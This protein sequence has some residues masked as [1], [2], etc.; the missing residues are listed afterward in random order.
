MLPVPF[1]ESLPRVFQ[2]DADEVR[3]A[4]CDKVD[5]ILEGLKSDVQDIQRLADPGAAPSE[6]LAAFGE[7]L[8][9]GIGTADA[10]PVKREKISGAVAGHKVRYTWAVVKSRIDFISGASASLYSELADNWPVRLGDGE[11][12]AVLGYDW[13]MRG[14]LAASD[15]IFRIGLGTEF[16]VPGNIFVDVGVST[17][18]AAQVAQIVYDITADGVP[19][20]FRITLGYTSGGAFVAYPGGVIG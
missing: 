9:A 2:D 19:A 12:Y 15:G 11:V 7:M 20:Y 4:L 8:A 17:L 10:E 6:G 13:S 3:D 14:G 5:G 1:R 18:T 16:I